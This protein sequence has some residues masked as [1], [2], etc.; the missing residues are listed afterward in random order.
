MRVLRRIICFKAVVFS[1]LH[2]VL[3][4]GLAAHPAQ[5]DA[6]VGADFDGGRL[7]GAHRLLHRLHQVLRVAHQHVGRLLVLLRVCERKNG[8][9]NKSGR[10]KRPAER[11]HH[12]AANACRNHFALLRHRDKFYFASVARGNTRDT[13]L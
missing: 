6:S 3:V 7:G 4:P 9:Q 8:R 1:A 5:A 10:N 2:L 13:L 12:D 11:M